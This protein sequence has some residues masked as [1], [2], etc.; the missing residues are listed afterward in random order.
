MVASTFIGGCCFDDLGALSKLAFLVTV[1]AAGGVA[2]V[3][4][5]MMRVYTVA[6]PLLLAL[7]GASLAPSQYLKPGPYIM[8]HVDDGCA[9]TVLALIDTPGYLLSAVSFQLYPQLLA[10]GGWPLIFSLLG[11]MIGL[12]ALSLAVQQ[13]MENRAKSEHSKQ[14]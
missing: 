7:L 5:G 14:E 12:A 4:L 6:V 10:A 2:A 9:P 11:L 13:W 1:T 3:L 8:L